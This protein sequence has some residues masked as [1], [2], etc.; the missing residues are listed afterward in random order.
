[1]TESFKTKETTL[2]REK[3]YLQPK[4]LTGKKTSSFCFL[5]HNKLSVEYW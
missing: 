2:P 1:M 3:K 5:G 4:L